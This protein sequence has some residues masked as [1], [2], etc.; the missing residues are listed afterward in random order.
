[1]T[2]IEELRAR[3]QAN[4]AVTDEVVRER[5]RQTAFAKKEE[6]RKRTLATAVG[7]ENPE[8]EIDLAL[9]E[10]SQLLKFRE[11]V[12]SDLRRARGDDEQEAL[13]KAELAEIEAEIS[14]RTSQG[15]G[16]FILFLAE[17]ER[18]EPTTGALRH[19]GRKAVSLGLFAEIKDDEAI[20]RLGRSSE[21]WKAGEFLPPEEARRVWR[22]ATGLPENGFVNFITRWCDPGSEATQVARIKTFALRYHRLFKRVG[23]ARRD[24]NEEVGNLDTR[25]TLDPGEIFEADASGFAKLDG[26]TRERPWTFPFSNGETGK[27]W[28]PVYLEVNDRKFAVSLPTRSPLRRSFENFGLIETGVL[29]WI[30]FGPAFANLRATNGSPLQLTSLARKLLCKAA[31][32]AAPEE[33]PEPTRASNGVK[34]HSPK[35]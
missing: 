23:T 19:F 27:V 7:N 33:K 32:I 26:L 4:A 13:L 12:E 18:A 31:G 3:R 22:V 16:E 35:S 14:A 21:A 9:Q 8:V 2:S 24:Y 25:A 10:L 20:L 34:E 11:G 30:A 29:K 17:L 5:Q 6:A 1:M 15:D 28:G